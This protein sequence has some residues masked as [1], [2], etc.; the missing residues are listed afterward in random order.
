MLFHVSSVENR[1]SILQ[2]G[3][4]WSQMGYARGIAGSH[5][6]EVEGVFLCLEEWEVDWFIDLNNTGG[7]V[8]VW[9][10]EGVNG[11]DLVESPNGHH[12]LARPIPPNQVILVRQDVPP[13]RIA[14]TR[15]SGARALLSSA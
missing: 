7:P 9:A 1:A 2:H 10:V 15:S 12:Y 3:L 5:R 14:D 6:P 4:D 8:D 11:D 13:G